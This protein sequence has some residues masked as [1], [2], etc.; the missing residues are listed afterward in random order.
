MG[1]KASG[2]AHSQPPLPG[3]SQTLSSETRRPAAPSLPQ[4]LD[5]RSSNIGTL[6][7]SLLF[8]NDRRDSQKLLAPV[9]SQS[10][11]RAQLQVVPTEKRPGAFFPPS[12]VPSSAGRCYKA[13]LCWHRERIEGD[14]KLKRNQRKSCLPRVS[15][16]KATLSSSFS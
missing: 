9:I 13:S 1:N 5:V 6:A 10:Q 16:Y 11:R 4:P 12:V 7:R 3:A 8:R 2:G 14:C 15:F